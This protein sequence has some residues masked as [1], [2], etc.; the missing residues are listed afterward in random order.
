MNYTEGLTPLIV[1][2]EWSWAKF[3]PQ[4]VLINFNRITP[5]PAFSPSLCEAAV[6][7]IQLSRRREEVGTCQAL[8]IDIELIK[9]LG[10]EFRFIHKRSEKKNNWG[11]TDFYQFLPVFRG[12]QD[13]MISQMSGGNHIKQIII[14]LLYTHPKV[15]HRIK[16]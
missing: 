13:E 8:E 10:R 7:V 14:P 12:C 4:P 16:S 1:D 3:P 15:E 9:N 2:V 6:G 5:K 11:V